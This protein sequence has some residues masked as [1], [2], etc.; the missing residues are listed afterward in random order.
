MRQKRWWLPALL[1]ALSAP[2]LLVTAAPQEQEK[3][4]DRAILAIMRRDGVMF[5]FAA[6]DKDNWEVPWPLDLADVQVPAR[7]EGIREKWWGMRSPTEWRLTLANGEA[8]SI[9]A[10]APSVYR[11]FCSQRLGIQTSYASTLPLPPAPVDPY[12]KDGLVTSPAFAVEPIESVNH[13]EWPALA[14]A[15]LKDFD[16]VEDRTIAGVRSQTGYR[17]P[18]AKEGRRPVPIHVESWY[19]SPTDKPGWTASYVELVR[20]YPPGP[21]DNGCGLETL[22]SGWVHHENGELK[23]ASALQ[24]KITYCDR[25]GATYML[26]LGRIRPREQ[27]YWVFQLSGWEDEWYDVA[28]V[29]P[30]DVRYVIEVYAGG[31]RSCR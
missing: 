19:R 6:F 16:R 13:A 21:S 25:V 10:K 24:G 31:R 12:P 18:I 4:I 2:P 14:A 23:D 9:T 26:P 7:L 29:R 20:Q 28:L 3:K 22:V 1:T 5:P 11:A 17:H 27:T 15:L 8:Q 30:R